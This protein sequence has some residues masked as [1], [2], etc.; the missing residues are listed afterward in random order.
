VTILRMTLVYLKH[1]WLRV[2]SIDQDEAR[3]VI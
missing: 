3:T 2:F 1:G